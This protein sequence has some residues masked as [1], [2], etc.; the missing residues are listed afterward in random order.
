MARTLSSACPAAALALFLLLIQAV[1]ARAEQKTIA[2]FGFELINT[3]PAPVSPQETARIEMLDKEA[4]K[5]LAAHGLEPVDTAS[6][7]A[8]RDAVAS[9][10]DCNG[11]DLDLARELGAELSSFGWVQ[12]VS[13]LILN[14]NLQIRDVASGR[15]IKAGSV[16][17]RGNTDKSWSRGLSFLMK[18]RI[19][20][21]DAGTGSN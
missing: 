7:A 11:C 14:I 20:R 1:P 21:K 12:K 16:D 6:V 13:N 3:S 4:R 2:F 18:D 17:I 5:A 10:R 9:L 8:K 19:F 15:L